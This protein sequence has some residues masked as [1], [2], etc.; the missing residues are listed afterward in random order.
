MYQS[1]PSEQ[2]IQK[3]TKW[4]VATND[5]LKE[6]DRKTYQKEYREVFVS[7]L[8]AGDYIKLNLKTRKSTEKS[9]VVRVVAINDLG[10]MVSLSIYKKGLPDCT[11]RVTIKKDNK[12]F[13]ENE[14]V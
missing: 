9:P 5:L 10:A 2:T 13:R 4:I 6:R 8:R 12:V 3:A 1:Q 14:E 11:Y 7:T